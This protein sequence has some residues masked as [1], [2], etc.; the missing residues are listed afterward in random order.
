MEFGGGPVLVTFDEWTKGRVVAS[1]G[2]NSGAD[3]LPFQSWRRFKEAFAPE[4][5]ARAVAESE[6]PIARCVD[7]FGG[8]GTT[9]LACQFLGIHPITV[10]VNPFLAD[11]I[12]AKLTVYNPDD[13]ARD[14]GAVIRAAAGPIGKMVSLFA[15]APKTFVEPGDKGRWIFDRGIADRMV[16]L[17]TG[18]DTLPNEDHGRLFRVLLGGILIDV[19]NV[20]ISGKGRRYRRNWD[21][22]P[23]IKGDVDDLFYTSALRAISDIHRFS[24]RKKTS[25]EV[26]RGDS[27][28]ILRNLKACDLAI[29]SPPY[30]NSFDY[31]DV[32]N[33]ELWTLG[34]L[35]DGASNRR[36]RAATL[37]SH[38]QLARDYCD[39]PC[40]S[41]TLNKTMKQLVARRSDLWDHRIP[42]MVGAYFADLFSVLTVST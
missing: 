25:Y 5:V 31:T 29:F 2:T 36:L 13:L 22:R 8:S 20:V 19:S 12:Q 32:Y 38:V 28:K 15:G 24:G 10:E 14:L 27:R 4:L 37:T 17:R 23:R 6:I 40:G 33:V 9:A 18:I 3:Q 21:Q 1:L 41:S 42:E 16:A 35:T 30:P 39:A 26:R 11:L 7:P 34:Y